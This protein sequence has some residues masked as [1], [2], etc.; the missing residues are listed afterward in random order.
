MGMVAVGG[1][2][3]TGPDTVYGPRW[4]NLASVFTYLSPDFVSELA[5]S[6]EAGFKFSIVM[7][8]KTSSRIKA[9]STEFE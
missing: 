8:I 4:F 7:L 3:K 1:S 2:T 9:S 6:V 5:L